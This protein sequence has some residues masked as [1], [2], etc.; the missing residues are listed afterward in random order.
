MR[1]YAVAVGFRVIP[2]LLVAGAL[3]AVGSQ[4]SCGTSPVPSGSE[5]SKCDDLRARTRAEMDGGGPPV[6]PAESGA[7]TRP[8]VALIDT[9]RSPPDSIHVAPLE[10]DFGPAELRKSFTV[11]SGGWGPAPFSIVPIVELEVYPLSGVAY[12]GSPV[13]VWVTTSRCYAHWPT[14]T[15]EF[16]VMVN[17]ENDDRLIVEVTV[18][19]PETPSDSAVVGWLEDLPTLPRPHHS[20]PANLAGLGAPTG[21]L[22][23]HWVRITRC[24]G[25]SARWTSESE[26]HDAVALCKWVNDDHPTVNAT[27]ALNYSPY[28]YIFPSDYPPTYIGPECQFEERLCDQSLMDVRMWVDQ[29]NLELGTDV[30]VSSVLLDTEL[31]LWYTKEP[32]DRDGEAWNAALDAK[33]DAIYAIC[34]T[35][36]PDV[37]VDWH[38]RGAPCCPRRFTTREQGDSYNAVC[39]WP[40]D[41]PMMR[42]AFKE[43]HQQAQADAV[44]SLQFWI[45]LGSG[46]VSLPPEDCRWICDFDHDLKYSWQLGAELNNPRYSRQPDVY[47][48]WDAAHAIVIYPGPS[49]PRYPS[50]YKHFRAYVRGAHGLPMPQEEA[51]PTSGA[52]ERHG[53]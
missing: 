52:D 19:V 8:D 38:Q 23:Y 6:L 12:P 18:D 26:V 10:V 13:T 2:L 25:I 45:S 47:A 1:A 40:H 27:I 14:G 33:Y 46:Y 20:W 21:L 17:G 39:Y 49:T 53:S 24:L 41:L 15:T 50:F 16:A 3:L 7:S 36:F 28:H 43:Y 30:Q 34:K 11:A 9:L 5:C 4:T 35:H 22:G 51:F 31:E 29:A 37:P 32:E 44:D 48:P 42:R